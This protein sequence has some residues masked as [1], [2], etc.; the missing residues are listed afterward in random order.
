[1]ARNR[2]S[3]HEL[4]ME[5]L[6]VPVVSDE[7]VLDVLRKWYFKS[8]RDR[9][10]VFPAGA[11][12]VHSDTLGAIRTRVGRVVPTKITMKNP[13]VFALLSRFLEDNIPDAYAMP[14]RFTSININFGSVLPIDIIASVVPPSPQWFARCSEARDMVDICLVRMVRGRASSRRIQHW[15][16]RGRSRMGILA[17]TSPPPSHPHPAQQDAHPTGSSTSLVTRG[18]G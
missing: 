11:T 17:S 2:R 15:Q 5:R 12:Y 16:A 4:A 18:P 6:R 9:T 13:A 1:M 8:N 7:D 3:A 10:N 14:F